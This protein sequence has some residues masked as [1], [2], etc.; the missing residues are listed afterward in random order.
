MKVHRI[1]E[2]DFPSLP[3]EVK[4]A[5]YKDGRSLREIVAAAGTTQ[6]HWR[7]IEEGFVKSLPL[8][9]VRN[10]EE[11]LGIDLGVDVWLKLE[12]G[13]FLYSFDTFEIPKLTK[14]SRSQHPSNN[15]DYYTPKSTET[16]SSP[17]SQP[18][19]TK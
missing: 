11:A 1:I 18:G 15:H 6:Q 14:I 19:W 16:P 17:D 13:N 10:I 4:R 9:T 5:R 7:R 3:E 12:A 8:E 2:Q